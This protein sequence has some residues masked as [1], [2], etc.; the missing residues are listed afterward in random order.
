MLSWLFRVGD[1]RRIQM[2][3]RPELR[4]V[5][6]S[7]QPF[8]SRCKDGPPST[9]THQCLSAAARWGCTMRHNRGLA[10]QSGV[11]FP[12]DGYSGWDHRLHVRAWTWTSHRPR[13][14]ASQGR[15]GQMIKMEFK[16]QLPPDLRQH[17]GCR[18]PRQKSECPLHSEMPETNA[19]GCFL[20][21]QASMTGTD[22]SRPHTRV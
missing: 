18:Q 21:K 5:C 19:Q 17:I 16:I 1:P 13:L 3:D 7:P 20:T 11:A 22:K 14:P 9:D 4:T 8:A 2:E 6:G 10:G 15:P 12:Q